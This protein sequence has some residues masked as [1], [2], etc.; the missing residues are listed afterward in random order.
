MPEKEKEEQEAKQSNNT[1]HSVLDT[2]PPLTTAP[3]LTD[4]DRIAALR[5]VADSVAQQRQIAARCV[6]FHPV[7][8]ALLALL[9]GL[10]WKFLYRDRS[11]LPLVGTTWAGCVMAGLVVV[12]AA[13]GGYLEVAERTGT[14]VWLYGYGKKARGSGRGNGEGGRKK[15]DDEENVVLVTKFGEEVIGALVMRAST[16][17]STSTDSESLS[18]SKSKE[19]SHLQKRPSRTPKTSPPPPPP[20]SSRPTPT[21]LIRAWTVKQRYRRKGVGTAL[22]EEAVALCRAKGWDG[23]VFDDNHA[24]AARVLPRMFN[25]RFERTERWARGVLEGV[26][27]R[28]RSTLEG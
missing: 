10:V 3:A 23:P 16:S 17:T 13:T 21:G 4:P 18:S 12:R 19:P 25:A 2:I 7:S 11:D 20:Q 28:S 6:I 22:L 9:L 1:T 27:R 14:W 5:L 15:E 8:L 26:V 24:N